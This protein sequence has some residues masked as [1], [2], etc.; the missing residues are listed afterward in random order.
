M[1]QKHD[2]VKILMKRDHM[3]LDDAWDLIKRTQDEVDDYTSGLMPIGD[4]VPMIEEAENV[5]KR[6]LNLGPEYLDAFFQW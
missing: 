1:M 3:T 4:L 5:I 2:I 6:N